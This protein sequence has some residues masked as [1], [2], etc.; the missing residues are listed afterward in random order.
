MVDSQQEYAPEVNTSIVGT[1]I[2][3]IVDSPAKESEITSSEVM[4]KS[5]NELFQS[6]QNNAQNSMQNNVQ[7][8][9]KTTKNTC[10]QNADNE[11][12]ARCSLEEE[13]KVEKDKGEYGCCGTTTARVI[14]STTTNNCQVSILPFL[15]C[16]KKER[17]R[18]PTSKL[19]VSNC[20]DGDIGE[21]T[22]QPAISSLL[23]SN[24]F[25]GD[26]KDQ[27]FHLLHS[28]PISCLTPRPPPSPYVWHKK[29]FLY[30][31]GGF[32]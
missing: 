17:S 8:S 11:G 19:L 2:P 6:A 10:L 25:D 27:R 22:N 18:K 9:A 21:M 26:C 23:V 14:T 13:S 7:N 4:Q 24:Y 1:I 31:S 29:L 5:A 30:F 32:A 12:V 15:V 16:R 3:I 20:F 28:S